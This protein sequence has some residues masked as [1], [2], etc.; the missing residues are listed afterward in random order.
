MLKK[1]YNKKNDMLII[2]RNLAIVI[3]FI[4]LIIVLLLAICLIRKDTNTILVPFGISDKVIVSS[5]KPQNSY[6]EAISRD[7]ISTMLNLQPNNVDYVEKTI[8]SYADGSSYGKLK[9]QLEQLKKN[10]VSKKFATTFYI[11]SIYPDNSN[12]KAVVD[13]LLS[14]YFGQKE[15]A[16]DKKKYEIKYNYEAGRLHII[17]F[18][19]IIDNT[20]KK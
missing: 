8:L 9:G 1:I 20:D 10:I 17:G 4:L 15:V 7:I 13:G 11:N 12:M 16:R 3:A 2:Q 18:S 14:T 19:E 5:K 6:L